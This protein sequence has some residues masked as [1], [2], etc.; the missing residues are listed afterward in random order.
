MSGSLMRRL[1]GVGVPALMAASVITSSGVAQPRDRADGQSVFLRFLNRRESGGYLQNPPHLGLSFG[2]RQRRAV[3]DTGSTGIV[4]SAAAIPDIDRLP[5]RGPAT[6]T[7]T[8]SGRIMRGDWVV[9]RVTITGANG[10]SVT[11]LPMPVLAVRSIA[12]L[13]NARNCTPKEDPRH[14]AMIGVGFGRRGNREGPPGP[15]KNPFLNLAG[16]GSGHDALRRG[17]I[18]SSAG[19]QIGLTGADPGDGYVTVQL[20]WDDERQ[21]WSGA[22]ACITIDERAPACGTVLPDTGVNGM[23]LSLPASEEEARAGSRATDRSLPPGTKVTILLAPGNAAPGNAAPEALAQ[24]VAS[25]SFRIGDVS[26]PFAPTR[27]T[28][29]GRGDRPTFVNTGV[30]LLNGFDY[31]FDAD[32]GVVGYRWNGRLSVR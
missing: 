22:S 3:M 12:C 2:G 21:D 10:A 6:L 1:I 15:E 25:Y 30:H 9:T 16:T 23:F 28:L 17:Y 20:P 7:Y 13:D 4:V 11:T 24:G 5:N 8:S 32:K 14:V 27:V 18:V 26:S 29:V 19:I 31:L